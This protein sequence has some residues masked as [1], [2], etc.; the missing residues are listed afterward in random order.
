MKTAKL[1]MVEATKYNVFPL[2]NSFS[3]RAATP[4]PSATAGRTV[5]TYLVSRP[6]HRSVR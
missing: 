2:D 5:F 1:I 3:A 6:L 4:R